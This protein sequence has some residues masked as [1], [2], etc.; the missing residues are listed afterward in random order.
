VLRVTLPL[1]MNLKSGARVIVDSGEPLTASYVTCFDTGC[2]ADYEANDDLIDKLKKGQRLIIQAI[3]GAG[4]P[5][6]FIMPLEDFAAAH[7]GPPIDPQV[8][9]SQQEKLQRVTPRI[10]TWHDDTL[11]R[12]IFQK[13]IQQ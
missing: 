4:K 9:A 1:S 11:Q 5:I 3:N 7:D 12:H 2:M 8:F 13:S 10:K 6:T